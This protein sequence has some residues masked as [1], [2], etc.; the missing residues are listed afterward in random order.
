MET[1]GYVPKDTNRL[2]PLLSS[3]VSSSLFLPSLRSVSGVPLVYTHLAR[4]KGKE[5]GRNSPQR[6]L[7]SFISNAA[8]VPPVSSF[9]FYLRSMVTSQQPLLPY[10]FPLF[11]WKRKGKDMEVA[12]V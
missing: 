5:T 10:L 11:H 6:H 9:P 8:V 7:F 4:G 2:S 1:A 3:Y 12:A